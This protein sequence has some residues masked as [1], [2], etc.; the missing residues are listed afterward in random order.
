MVPQYLPLLLIDPRGNQTGAVLITD[1]GLAERKSQIQI[2]LFFFRQGLALSPRLECGGATMAHCSLDLLGLSDPPT[3]T[4]I[5]CH[6]TQLILKF[7]FSV[8][9]GSHYITQAGIELL[10]SRDPLISV[11]QSAGITVVSHCPQ[12][13][14]TILCPIQYISK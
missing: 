5:T 9:T 8:Q 11:S 10:Y 13:Q 1:E 12:P 4:T 2:S 3:W 14:F 7:L 6:H